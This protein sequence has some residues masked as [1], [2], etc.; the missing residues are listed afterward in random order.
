MR[1]TGL[2]VLLIAGCAPVAGFRP[3]S[4]AMPGRTLELGAGAAAVSPRPYVDETWQGAGQLWL[5]LDR[6]ELLALS[7]IA[8]FDDDAVA[9]GGAARLGLVRHDRFAGGV[10]GE[11]GFAWAA[12]SLPLAVR[13]F[14]QNWIY[15]APRLGTWSTDA[16]IGLPLGASVHV[17]DGLILRAEAQV[18]WQDFKYYNRRTTLGAGAAYQF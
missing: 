2:L 8:A 16:L 6:S 7:G 10:E 14:E 4:G 1:K 3:A 15:S 13:A 5:T 12:L 9:L 17:Y 18:S 11:L